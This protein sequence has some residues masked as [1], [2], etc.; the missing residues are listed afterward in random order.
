MV[1]F[2]QVP[3]QVTSREEWWL[4]VI[5]LPDLAAIGNSKIWGYVELRLINSYLL[6]KMVVPPNL[7]RI[8]LS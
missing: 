8:L 3:V 5:K 6:M 2:E 7:Y 4:S 1:V